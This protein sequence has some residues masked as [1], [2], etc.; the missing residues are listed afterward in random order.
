[1]RL[2]SRRLG[3]AV[4]VV[5]IAAVALTSC[6]DDPSGP[7]APLT[8]YFALAP[9]FEGSAAGIVDLDRVRVLVVRTEDSTVALDTIVQIPA[10]AD[11]LDLS[12]PVL[13]NS[14]DEIFWMTMQ[15]IT[16]AGDTA[17]IG[18]PLTVTATT[19]SDVAP[20]AA[21]L[22]IED[23]G[24]GFDAADVRITTL[25]PSVPFYDTLILQAE[26]LDSSDIVIEGTPIE[27]TSLDPRVTVPD[28]AGGR[29][30]GQPQRGWAN[31]SDLSK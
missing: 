27:W 22:P 14:A 16:P 30:V 18:G 5:S 26:A 12:L 1:M 8:G 15:F 13:L 7:L 3:T 9:S 4:L 2:L 31:D 10:E 23:V 11:S 20:V 28:P 17:F 19:A 29:V 24:V 25:D 21:Q 6:Q